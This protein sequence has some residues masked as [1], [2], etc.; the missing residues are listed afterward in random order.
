MLKKTVLIPLIAT[1]I[2]AVAIVVPAI[3][4]A[5]KNQTNNSTENNQNNGNSNGNN[6]NQEYITTSGNNMELP[7][8][9]LNLPTNSQDIKNFF[10][11]QLDLG[12]AWIIKNK[13][14]L[15]YGETKFLTSPEQIANIL[16]TG[17]SKDPNKINLLVELKPGSYIDD[18][19]Q[20]SQTVK[21]FHFIIKCA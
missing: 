14:I 13:Q 5:S 9:S 1:P 8:A 7:A 16:A 15:F 18:N 2:V 11:N 6:I 3:V 4:F 21:P 10:N 12:K 17:D 19:G 20:I